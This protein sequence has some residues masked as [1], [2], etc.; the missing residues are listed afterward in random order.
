MG[1]LAAFATGVG[2][3]YLGARRYLDTKDRAKKQ[4][5]LLEKALAAGKATDP[6]K[7]TSAAAASTPELS[8]NP[9]A[10]A[11]GMTEEEAKAAGFAHGGMIGEMPHHFDKMS[12]QRQTFKKKY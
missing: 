4:D 10:A 11:L 5:D 2:E 6:A 9:A 12:W 3:G 7:S 8:S 1:K